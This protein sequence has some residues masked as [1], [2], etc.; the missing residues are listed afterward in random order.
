MSVGLEGFH[1][2]SPAF[3]IRI[4]K[5]A[6]CTSVFTS[7]YSFVMLSGENQKIHAFKYLYE[8]LEEFGGCMK[9]GRLCMT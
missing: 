6:M 8:K 4:S 1:S 3:S 7:I 9:R 2:Y 5:A